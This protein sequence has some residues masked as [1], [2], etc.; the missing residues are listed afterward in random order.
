LYSDD[1]ILESKSS[2]IN[3]YEVKEREFFIRANRLESG[4]HTLKAKI[5]VQGESVEEVDPSNNERTL[6]IVVEEE[7][8]LFDTLK[9]IFKWVAVVVI[10]LGL[11]KIVYTFI[12]EREED[13]LR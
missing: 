9:P 8:N 3:A 10:I 13:Y 7:T 6:D 5:L 1:E 11:G 2:D 4:S 12:M